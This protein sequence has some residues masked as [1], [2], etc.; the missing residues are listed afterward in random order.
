MK[1]NTSNNDEHD[2]K[3][4]D[5]KF[6]KGNKQR[7]EAMVLVALAREQGYAKALDDAWEIVNK[8]AIKTASGKMRIP[9]L[10]LEDI[11]EQITKLSHSQQNNSLSK[12]KVLA[13]ATFPTLD[14]NFP[15]ADTHIPKESK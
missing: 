4:L 11:K 8:T 14:N 15:S 10:I 9:V 6:P 7:G 3:Y 13:K 12:S 1:P 2:I 5:E